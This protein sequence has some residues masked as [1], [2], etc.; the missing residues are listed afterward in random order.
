MVDGMTT[1]LTA[2]ELAIRPQPGPQ[3][4]FLS[5]DADI[6]LYGGGAGG[7]KTWAS[8]MDPLRFV[9]IPDFH[10]AVFRRVYPEIRNPDGMWDQSYR[11]Y[12]LV[13]GRPR[14]SDL[15][16]VFPSGATIKFAHMQHE[17]NRFDWQGAQV[18][19]IV[20]D[21]LTHFTYSQF[22]YML[23]RNRST[24]GVRP[25][26]R[27]TCNPDPDSFVLEFVQWYLTSDGYVDPLK[28]G[29]CRYFIR[30]QADKLV[31]GDSVAELH[32][33]HPGCDPKSFVFISA[34]LIDN[35]I[36]CKADPG[37]R[38][39]L[40]ALPI[41]ER[42][43]LLAGNWYARPT[44][45]QVFRRDWLEI[46]NAAP[47]HGRKVRYW[48]R[49]ATAPS[50]ANRDPDWTVGLLLQKTHG[51]YYI[52]DVNRFRVSPLE[53][54]QNIKAIATQDDAQYGQ[55]PLIIE[56]DPAQAGKVE[57]ADVI[58]Y[59]SGHTVH[60]YT[61]PKE[62]RHGTALSRITRAGPVSAQA[63]ARNIKL[64]K[65]AWNRDLI[66]ELQAFPDGG[67]DDQVSALTGAFENLNGPEP[68]I[69]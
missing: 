31:W 1:T 20:F 46:V 68:R 55:V 28:D 26:I 34:R 42:D 5:C 3:E 19:V 51:V 23:S 54:R 22:M 15:T 25:Y 67:H 52:L 32:E 50:E 58:A 29:R 36:L 40:N 62:S 16:W 64:V 14:E 44:A 38:A 8:L 66:D 57:A 53:V 60:A 69:S 33:A 27:A 4:A 21:E 65:G 41:Y 35:P 45:G 37:Y 43:R 48:D 59:L 30:T 10:A 18:P 56:Q 39:N 17:K 12:P 11:L 6:A 7:G 9:D 63:E 24:C 61:P 49:A 13:G 47:A 2:S